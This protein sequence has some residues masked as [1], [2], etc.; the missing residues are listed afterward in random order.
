MYRM[1]GIANMVK[2]RDTKHYRSLK[3]RVFRHWRGYQKFTKFSSEI[4]QPNALATDARQA[5]TQGQR[6]SATATAPLTSTR[7]LNQQPVNSSFGL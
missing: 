6:N 5:R 1:S 2:Q 7:N 4:R 3:R